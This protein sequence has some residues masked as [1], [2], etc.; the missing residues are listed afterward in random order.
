MIT[1]YNFDVMKALK[2]MPDES[3]DCVITSPPYYGLRNYN[4][5]SVIFDGEKDCEHEFDVKEIDDPMY[6]AG[7]GDHDKE[8]LSGTKIDYKKYRTG[9]CKKC[10]AWL[11]N[12]GLE[13][14]PQEYINHLVEIFTEIMRVLKS[15]GVFF[16]NIGDCYVTH[17]SGRDAE[18]NIS[19]K[20]RLN[21]LVTRNSPKKSL[22]SNWF[23]EKQKL[24]I[25]HRI[26]IALQEKGFLIRDDI[27]WVKK[28]IMYPD[29]ESI[30]SC[31]PFPVKDKLL[32]ATEYIFQ[33]TKSPK[34]FFNLEKVKTPIKNSTIERAKRPLSSTYKNDIIGNPYVHHKGMEKAH[35][36][37]ANKCVGKEDYTNWSVKCIEVENVNPTNALMFK[38]MNQFSKMIQQEHFA[39]FPTSLVDYKDIPIG[40]FSKEELIKNGVGDPKVNKINEHKQWAVKERDGFVKVRDLPYIKE[41]SKYINDVRKQ[42]S[43]TIDEIEE[44][45]GN[46]SPHHWF[47][48]ESFPNSRD[49]LK[50]KEILSLDNRY[51]KNI[52]EEKYKS[53]EKGKTKY[54]KKIISCD[55]NVGFVKGIVL[56]PFVGS[57]TTLLVARKLHMDSIGIELSPK[58]VKII[59]KRLFKKNKPLFPEEIKILK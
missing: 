55:C 48:A 19:K 22:K 15:T 25:P 34:Y 35:E 23:Q 49:Y 45:Y 28:L 13:P 8:G 29:K 53:A 42:A 7:K 4:I 50:L 51:D 26:A 20:E 38:R 5:E 58:F 6:R 14:T 52:I 1:I 21:S 41:F 18:I 16:L 32:P 57:G 56:D 40:E 54:I 44:I 12:I 10:N 37:W 39:S 27:V 17:R 2:Q 3:V 46:Q 9:Y 31:M 36:R 30:G 43:K 59:E 33:I 24:L 11:G 47:N